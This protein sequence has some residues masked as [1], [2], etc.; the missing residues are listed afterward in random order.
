M[1]DYYQVL[2]IKPD[3]SSNDLKKAYRRLAREHH[4]DRN[5]G[6]VQ[7]EERFKEIQEAYGVL[8][9]PEKKK[10]YDRMRRNPFGRYGG[11]TN[12]SE[13]QHYQRAPDGTFFRFE[14]GGGLEDL[15]GGA[16]S[17]TDFFGK[18]FGGSD[19][20]GRATSRGQRR[21]SRANDASTTLRIPFDQALQG[22]K[23]EVTLPSG[24][25]I[26]IDVPKGV[27]TGFKIRLKGHGPAASEQAAGSDLYVTFEVE[28]HPTFRRKG[29]DLLTTVEIGPFDAV[30][31]T[32]RSITNPYGK[33][34]KVKI[35]EGAQPGDKLRLKGLGVQTEKAVGDLLVVIEL[36]IPRGLTPEQKQILR[37]ARDRVGPL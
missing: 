13:S 33:K 35:P 21:G 18:M 31:G 16:D 28:P 2:G 9:D 20:T 36:K 26:R 22:G 25:T 30:L 17:V 37:E 19:P 4:P 29:T 24:K 32:T 34:V 5:P 8:S 6:N 3:A 1:K 12:A 11:D 27:D 7:A 10:R 14:G 23:T 15:F